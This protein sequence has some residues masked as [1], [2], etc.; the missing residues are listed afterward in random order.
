MGGVTTAGYVA[1][2]AGPADEGLRLTTEGRE[3]LRS[4][5]DILAALTVRGGITLDPP[6]AR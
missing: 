3:I 4:L 5:P 1:F 6:L 2:H